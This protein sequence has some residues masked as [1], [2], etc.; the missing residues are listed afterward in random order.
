M[1][2][3]ILRFWAKTTHDAE[4]C[5]NAFH[6]LLCHLIDVGAAAWILWTKVLPETTKKRLAK[7]FGFEN[8]NDLDKAGL[9]TAFLIA[10]HDLG[11][12]SPPFALRGQNELR[13]K[14]SLNE[15]LKKHSRKSFYGKKVWGKL[16]TIEFLKLY[17]N[18]DCYCEISKSAADAPHNFVTAVILPPILHKKFGFPERLAGNV[19]EIIGGHHGTFPDSNHLNNSQ[20]DAFC[21]DKHWR[22]SQLELTEKLAELFGIKE[23][24][25]HLRDEKLE[26]ATAMIFAGLTTVADWIGSNTDF[27]PSKIEDWREVLNED[28][29]WFALEDYFEESK[30]KA[31]KAFKELGWMDWVRK[32]D[33]KEFDEL[34]SELKG[35]HRDLQEVAIEIADEL[36]EVGIAVVESPMGEGKTEA[37]MFLADAWNAR[38]GTRGI[39]FALPTQATSNQ[40]F[41]RVKEFLRGRFADKSD[42]FVHLL[43]QHGHS[44]IS[45]EFAENIRDFRNI[46]NTYDDAAEKD[47]KSFSNVVAAEWFTY[48]KRGLLVPFGVGTIDQILLAV[49]QTKHVFVRL[50]GLAHKT[51][52]IDEVHAYDAY[53]STLLER[54]LEWLAALGSPVVILSATL[55]KKKRD[56]LIKA[57]LKGLG[58]AVEADQITAVGAD[59]TYPRI[60]YAT[61]ATDDKT[62]KVRHLN[63]S[64]QN[65]KT[66]YLEWKNEDDFIDELKAKLEN[67]GCAAIICNTVDKAQTLYSKLSS[68]KFFTGKASDGE[69]KL[70]LLH[71]RFR[72]KDREQR[73]QRALLRFGKEGAKVNVVKNGEIIEKIVK[74]PD[75]AVLITT[76][77][78]E[79]SLDLDFD[80]MISELA[81]AD[82][83][84]QRA[85]RLQR[86]ERDRLSQ[87]KEKTALWLIKPPTDTNGDLIVKD[88]SPDF[89]GSGLIYDKHILLRSWLRLRNEKKIEI[90]EDIENLIEDV[91]N[92]KLEC[93]DE[94]Y[95][96]IW[97]ETKYRLN[98]KLSEKRIKAK[99]VYLTD[100]DDEDFYDSFKFQL[101]ED[102]PE[103]HQTLRAHTR[104]EERPTVSIVLLKKDETNSINLDIEPNRET[105][106]FLI[107]REVKISRGGLTQDILDSPE[108]KKSIWE[109]SS[110][111]RHHRLIVLDEQNQKVI[112]KTILILDDE[113]GVEYKTAGG[114]SE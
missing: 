4:S 91:Y 101:D 65:T 61:A 39:Y 88:N 16:Q 32:I 27:F 60:S 7:A 63:T 31:A 93:F 66:L 8:D 45:A 10:L 14:N 100:F 57:Y 59:K 97:E 17:Q 50:F 99:A 13:N 114:K 51:V 87:F 12:C 104:D 3:E 86:H 82:L 33:E 110:L 69:P 38:L 62:F 108:F 76:Q 22:K 58:K 81:P 23:N 30:Q 11:K 47:K 5:E 43:L 102:D 75:C 34:F 41:G 68:D 113:K 95:S 40:M 35:R 71:A 18:T 78:I 73:E 72:F 67:G 79:Q 25:S 52:I 98:K 112:G 80:L 6:P 54:L 55:P 26:N 84:L 105:S 106:E 42:E 24:F 49:L 37:A 53:M 9:L 1:K 96:N 2:T 103:K 89:G 92:L 85:G 107:K 28:F 64:A 48:K 44:S 74:R 111:L 70:D 46:Q 20:S 94:K 15:S 29:E 56:A 109:K 83:L 19:A 21:G 77:V 90:P 36:N